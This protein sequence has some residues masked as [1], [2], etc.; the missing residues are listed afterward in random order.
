MNQKPLWL[1]RDGGSQPWYIISDE[2]LQWDESKKSFVALNETQMLLIFWPEEFE[3]ISDTRLKPG[4]I[5][6][7][8]SITVK[9]VPVQKRKAVI[10]QQVPDATLRVISANEP[11]GSLF[12]DMARELI[13]WRDD[14]Q[15]ASESL[16]KVVASGS[17]VPRVYIEI[18]EM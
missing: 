2:P 16:V 3:R 7:V 18:E 6:E 4:E 11:P 1:S 14:S 10:D 5:R 13:A 8:E 17:E 15:V 9:L 12:G